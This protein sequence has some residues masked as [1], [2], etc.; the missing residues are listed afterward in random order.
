MITYAV[1][2][3]AGI[4][5]Q[6]VRLVA[7]EIRGLSAAKAIER[8]RFVEKKAAGFVQK[9]LESALANAEH[10]FGSDIDDLMV[11]EVLVDGAAVL[12]RFKPRAK[13]RSNRILK[14]RCHIRVSVGTVDK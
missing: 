2:R 13:G 11:K 1:H 12:R 14:R 10:N 6:K 4:S 3:D 5:P 8:L 9:V 7:K